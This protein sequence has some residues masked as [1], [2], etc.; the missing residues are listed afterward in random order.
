M[1]KGY[2]LRVRTALMHKQF[3]QITTLKML[4]IVLYLYVST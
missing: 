1:I 3:K 2:V 4:L